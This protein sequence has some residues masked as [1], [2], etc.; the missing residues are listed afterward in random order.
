M[1][2]TEY[3]KLAWRNIWRN[4]RRTLITVAS[5]FFALFFALVMRSLQKGSYAHMTDS[6]VRTFTG[7]IQ[8]HKNGYWSDK[9]INNCFEMDPGLTGRIASVDNV[10]DVVP[11]LESFALASSE[12][13]TKG[14]LV[15]GIDPE[16]ELKLTHPEKKLSEGSYLDNNSDG[17][18]VSRKLAEFLTIGLHDTLTL[19]SQGYHAATAAGLFPVTGIVDIPNPELDRR[20]VYM[21]LQ[22]AQYF[23][24]TGNMV[25][26][27]ILN[28]HDPGQLAGTLEQIT[29]SIDKEQYEVMDWKQL[30][31][32]LVQQIEG[33]QAG[34]FIMLGVLYLIVGFGVLG[35]LIMMTTERKREFG[36]MVAVGMQ[37]IR[38]GLVLTTE[39]IIL[40]FIGI[41]SGILG[42]LPLISFL[43]QHP[44]EITGESAEIFESFGIEPIMPAA[45]E[46]GYFIGQSLVVLVIFILAIIYPIYTVTRLKEIKAIRS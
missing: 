39:M 33:D 29:G 43:V 40:G 10:S 38:L 46:P 25:S 30:N 28:L 32:V 22:T 31:P 34:G 3:F 44:I 4:K 15:V 7:F 2:M 18:M 27:L 35:T 14:I 42:S 20:L 36:V 5:I 12:D 23:Y 1:N 11:R 6:V 26:S 45:F 8:I 21:N 41:V 9:T 17:V 24:G 13:K 16:K 37:K 19:I